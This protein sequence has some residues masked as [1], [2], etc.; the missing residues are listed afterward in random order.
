MHA[1]LLLAGIV[2]LRSS[3]PA[4]GRSW[5]F[6]RIRARSESSNS[7]AE[8]TRT[9]SRLCGST[10]PAPDAAAAATT[11]G[12]LNVRGQARRGWCVA[13]QRKPPSH[14]WMRVS[15]RRT[16]R[17]T[18]SPAQPDQ[19]RRVESTRSCRIRLIRG[20]RE[21]LV[22]LTHVLL[23][24][25]EAASAAASTSSS[26]LCGADPIGALKA[27]E[28]VVSSQLNAFQRKSSG[29]RGAAEL[30]TLR[31]AWM[32]SRG[33]TA[34]AGVAGCALRMLQYIPAKWHIH[35]AHVAEALT[36]KMQEGARVLTPLKLP[37]TRLSRVRARSES[38]GSD[39]EATRTRSRLCGSM[40]SAPD[41]A[42]TTL[43]STWGESR[44]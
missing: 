30:V 34:A 18:R 26:P 29:D 31:S 27:R 21:V 24:S 44:K 32:G 13:D 43:T 36:T 16:P 12:D 5:A 10:P 2:A 3:A 22:S 40:P 14:L 35:H 7:D 23:A 37:E 17:C 25:K 20:A 6:R 28:L 41:A 42:V 8:A 9:R 4:G 19:A 38:S 11:T 39:A 1:R 33:E 15:V